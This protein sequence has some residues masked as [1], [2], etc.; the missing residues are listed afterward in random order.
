MEEQRRDVEG[1]LF[2]RQLQERYL[3]QKEVNQTPWQI[4]QTRRRQYE[5]D[6]E[7]Y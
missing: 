7:L 4:E 6:K 5:A 2:D 3:P 1:E